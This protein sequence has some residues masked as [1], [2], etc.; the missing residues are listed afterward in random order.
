VRPFGASASRLA[1]VLLLPGVMVIAGGAVAR[2][3]TQ[4]PATP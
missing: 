3:R 2:G 1:Q 4:T